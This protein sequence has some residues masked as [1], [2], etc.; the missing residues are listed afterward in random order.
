MVTLQPLLR[1]RRL[2][3]P[4]VRPSVPSAAATAAEEKESIF[5]IIF[6]RSGAECMKLVD[7]CGTVLFQF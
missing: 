3:R 4:S 7:E 5:N 2:S 6:A 1:A